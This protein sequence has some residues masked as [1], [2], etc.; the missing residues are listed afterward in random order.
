MRW[1]FPSVHVRIPGFRQHAGLHRAGQSAGIGKN[2]AACR[3]DAGEERVIAFRAPTSLE[4]IPILD[5]LGP[6]PENFAFFI[7]VVI[8]DPDWWALP[9][10]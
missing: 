3:A 7:L 8:T 5:C 1:R 2:S 6:S 4:L 9:R 10:A